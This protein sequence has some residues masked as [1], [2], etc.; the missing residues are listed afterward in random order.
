[1][2]GVHD[3]GGMMGFGPIVPEQDEP[4][5]HAPWEGRTLAM[6]I[7]MGP[8]GGWGADGGRFSRE[9]VP[10]ADYLSMS[11]YE[12]WFA[13]LVRLLLADGLITQAEVEAGRMLEAAKPV[14]GILEAEAV[15]PMI[16]K[17]RPVLR[18]I[19]QPAR[20]QVGGQVRAKNIHPIGHTR[21]PRY[22]R[23][24]V[25]TITH[26]HGAHVFPDSSAAGKGENP[27]WLYTVRFTGRELWG[28]QADT[29]VTVSVDAWESYLEPLL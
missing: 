1:M 21:L 24:H 11:Y 17:G 5:F 14:A 15:A 26:V 22:V 12:L 25:G 27:Q 13:G 3:M 9:S 8:V 29:D 28:D 16:A 2:N 10:P 7:A 4:V 20:F 6:T 23:G 18:P 19:D